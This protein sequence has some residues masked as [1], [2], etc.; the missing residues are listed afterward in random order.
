MLFF[1]T[2]CPSK[3]EPRFPTKHSSFIDLRLANKKFHTL[4]GSNI[5]HLGKFGKSS[6]QKCRKVSG[7]CDLSLRKYHFKSPIFWKSSTFS[8]PNPQI[9]DWTNMAV[10]HSPTPFRRTLLISEKCFRTW[11][12]PKPQALGDGCFLN[13]KL[14]SPQSQEEIKSLPAMVEM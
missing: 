8:D 7:I 6:T 13:H 5:S 12:L 9:K 11:L 10:Q 14:C 1:W 4:Q 2:W 3:L